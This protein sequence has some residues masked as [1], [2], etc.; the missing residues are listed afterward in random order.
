MYKS[1]E[2]V[3][4]NREFQ[5]INEYL[6]VAFALINTHNQHLTNFSLCVFAVD[7]S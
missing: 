3:L 1:E 7:K 5:T 2:N 4:S 6:E